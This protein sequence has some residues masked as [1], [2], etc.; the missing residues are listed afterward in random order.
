MIIL[1]HEKMHIRNKSI[2]DRAVYTAKRFFIVYF[3]VYTIFYSLFSHFNI[4]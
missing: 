2:A 3:Y 4:T 1:F